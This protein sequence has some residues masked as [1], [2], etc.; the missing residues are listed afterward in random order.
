MKI[1]KIILTRYKSGSKLYY[2]N[3]ENRFQTSNNPVN[4]KCKRKSPAQNRHTGLL[5]KES[6]KNII[7]TII[8]ALARV[9]TRAG[10]ISIGS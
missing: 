10:H 4:S 1:K 3:I 5:D 6:V 8:T 7:E 2:H 9:I